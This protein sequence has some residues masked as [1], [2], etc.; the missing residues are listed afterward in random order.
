MTLDDRSLD[1]LF[2]TAHTYQRWL[3]RPVTDETLKA[4]YDLMK[5]GPTASNSCPARI[6]FVRSTQAKERLLQALA[7]GNVAKT[8]AAPVTAILAWDTAFWELMG[9]LAPHMDPRKAFE[10]K[11]ELAHETAYRSATLQGGYFI[12][13]ARALGLD[14]GPMS[15]FDNAKLDALF[16]ADGRYKSNFLVNLGYGEEGAYYP[17]APRLDFEVAARIE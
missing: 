6:V 3:D 14:C 9:P 15:G 12:L 13:A 1:Q 4:L 8:R 10:G 11:P 17:R 7:A 16:F 5:W 2:R